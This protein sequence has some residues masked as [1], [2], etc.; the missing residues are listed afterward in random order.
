M[1]TSS[2][3][4]SESTCDNYRQKIL[5]PY[6]DGVIEHLNLR[7][8][9]QSKIALQLNRLLQTNEININLL[10]TVYSFYQTLLNCTQMEF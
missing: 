1:S 7:F 3:L 9:G 6:I 8:S 5:I 2:N 4:T 10:E